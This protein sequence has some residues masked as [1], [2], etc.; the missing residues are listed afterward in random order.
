[1]LCNIPTEN[2]ITICFKHMFKVNSGMKTLYVA[3]VGKKDNFL[4][5]FD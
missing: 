4:N 5:Q 2:I 1:M 3:Q